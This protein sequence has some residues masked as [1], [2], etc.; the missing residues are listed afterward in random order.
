VNVKCE[1]LEGVDAEN[2]GEVF[3][4]SFISGSRGEGREGIRGG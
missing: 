4:K 1:F 3:K 2:G